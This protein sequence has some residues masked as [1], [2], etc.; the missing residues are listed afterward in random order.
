MKIGCLP[1]RPVI[2]AL[3]SAGILRSGAQ[4]YYGPHGIFLSLIPIAYLFFNGFLIFAVAKRDVKHLK[5]AQR[6]TVRFF[7]P[8]S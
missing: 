2:Y 8:C 4:F 1:I 5:W 6:L 3:A 7:A